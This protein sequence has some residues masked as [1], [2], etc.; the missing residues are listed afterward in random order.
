[1]NAETPPLLGGGGAR[2]PGEITDYEGMR[3][4]YHRADVALKLFLDKCRDPHYIEKRHAM[5]LFI[6]V[7]AFVVTSEIALIFYFLGENLG[8]AS[9]LYASLVAVVFI[10]C[11]SFGAAFSHANISRNLPAWRR[12]AG[13]AGIVLSLAM[14]LYG[15]GLLSGWRADSVEVGFSA[16]LDGYRALA[17]LPVFVTALVNAFGF[18]LLTYETRAYFWPRYWGYR[19][20]YERYSEA[21]S[22]FKQAAQA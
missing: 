8:T 5:V 13:F 4:E 12:A 11:S 21:R 19:P 17:E 14:F 2:N 15:L 7:L 10:A 6:A 18:A 1:M 20:V 9:A 22:R 16:V 3:E